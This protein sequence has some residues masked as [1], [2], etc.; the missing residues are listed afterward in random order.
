MLSRYEAQ[1]PE[2][3]DVVARIRHLVAAHVDCFQRTCRPGHVTAS[4]W[5][6]TPSVD[7]FLLVHHRKLDRW[8]QPGGHVDGDADILVAALREAREE[9]GLENL[10]LAD[11]GPNATPL[12]VD[13]HQIP[14]RYSPAGEL[15]EDAHEHHD[16]RMLVF[17][18]DDRAPQ[19]SDES[20]AV[21]WFT[22]EELL[23]VTTE[24]SVLRMMRKAAQARATT[25]R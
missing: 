17:A 22:H 25:F 5:V 6:A 9:T 23:A 15:I 13:V 14:A 24:E 12:D 10:H 4:A 21:K 19:V 2:E 1:R 11:Q 3:R 7:R 20:H 8:L 16:I 18:T